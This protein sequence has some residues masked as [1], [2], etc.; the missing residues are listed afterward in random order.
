[1]ALAIGGFP[2]LDGPYASMLRVTMAA[3]D[4]AV[5]DAEHPADGATA[6]PAVEPGDWENAQN[7][8]TPDQTRQFVTLYQA[9]QG[10]DDRATQ[11]RITCPRL[12]FAGSADVIPYGPKWGDVVVNIA[13]PLITERVE[14]E[15]LGWEVRV[16]D[17]LDHLQAMQ[18]AQVIPILR[19][20]LAAQALV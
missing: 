1:M 12:C 13:G 10:F 5:A 8:M 19:S 18:A 15:R 14:L 20:W 9:L 6:Q 17:E 7:T 3:H 16:L 4:L 11:S 2:P